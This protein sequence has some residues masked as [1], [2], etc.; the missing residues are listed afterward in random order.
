MA[1][2]GE[3]LANN[4][5][6]QVTSIIYNP[7]DVITIVAAGWASYGPTQKWGPQGDREHPGQGLICHDAF[8]GALVMKIGNSGTI[9]VN[10]G[11]FRWV[12]PSNV[13]G[14]ITLIYNDVPGT[15]GNN[16][17]SFSVNIGKDQS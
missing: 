13:Q 7:G 8:C 17:G 15:Y 2:K 3:V 10:T 5:A 1:W 16:S 12:A 9:P 14:A 6:G 4:E 11:L